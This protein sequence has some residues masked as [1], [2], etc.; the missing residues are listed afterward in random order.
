[1][2]VGYSRGFITRIQQWI[3][4]AVP[5]R[6]RTKQNLRRALQRLKDI[7]D[8]RQDRPAPRNAA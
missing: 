5:R 8:M 1:M 7:Q 6:H 3:A 4:A 2:A